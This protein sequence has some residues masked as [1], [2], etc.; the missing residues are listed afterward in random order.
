MYGQ[1]PKITRGDDGK[2]AITRD[3]KKT[4]P[5][6]ATSAIPEEVA[7][8]QELEKFE[9]LKKHQ[10]DYIELMARHTAEGGPAVEAAVTEEKKDNA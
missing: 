8:K 3:E 2:L 6:A 9:L 4:A 7:K 1:S 10:Q 5:A